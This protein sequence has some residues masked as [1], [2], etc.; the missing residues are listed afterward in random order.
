MMMVANRNNLLLLCCTGAGALA[1]VLI[2]LGLRRRRRLVQRDEVPGIKLNTCYVRSM[3]E[4]RSWRLS[5]VD[6]MTAASWIT[7]SV[8]FQANRIVSF[9]TLRKG[10]RRTL[11]Q[12]PE[13]AGRLHC[14][15]RAWQIILDE[16]NQGALFEHVAGRNPK[17]TRLPG[18]LDATEK[19]AAA[20]L[21]IRHKHNIPRPDEALLHARLV[22]Y[23]EERVSY[24]CIQISHCLGDA[25]TYVNFLQHWA[26][27]CSRN[28]PLVKLPPRVSS[29]VGETLPRTKNE[30]IQLWQ[31]TI[32]RR[33]PPPIVGFLYHAKLAWAFLWNSRTTEVLELHIDGNG[34]E[35]LKKQLC[36]EIGTGEWLSKYEVTMAMI[37][38]ARKAADKRK[39]KRKIIQA[40]NTR[41]RALGYP[42]DYFGNAVFDVV[43]EDGVEI[44]EN[45]LLKTALSFHRSLRSEIAKGGENLTKRKNWK[46]AARAL[47]LRSQIAMWFIFLEC[48]REESLFLNTWLGHRW[49][50]LDFGDGIR[51][52]TFA[53]SIPR[54]PG[55]YVQLPRHEDGSSTISIALPKSE[56]QAFKNY[57]SAQRFPMTIL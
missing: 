6:E 18:A 21:F 44:D 38:C 25:Q 19:W 45:S 3:A 5:E 16:L 40:V 36:S 55:L 51:T 31:D 28:P 41:D 35:Q 17:E 1:G 46:E 30:L 14:S 11:T 9:E 32:S 42:Q 33:D 29:Y 49:F 20:G 34:V 23:E 47:G 13:A 10:L 12:Y 52:T 26:T 53:A 57:I 2:G 56:I 24:L 7:F 27:A 22:T 4:A 50:G 48:V 8:K 37:L 43:L 54:M 15:G 39:R